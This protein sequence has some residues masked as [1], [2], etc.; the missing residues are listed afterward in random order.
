MHIELFPC[1]SWGGLGEA[2]GSEA[3]TCSFSD[4]CFY[5]VLTRT[6][7]DGSMRIAVS[8]VINAESL[9]PLHFFRT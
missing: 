8:A 3:E 6:Q 7:G 9:S 4:S 1:A 5:V 2:A